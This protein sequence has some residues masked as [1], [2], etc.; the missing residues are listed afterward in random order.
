[1]V[2]SRQV[3]KPSLIHSSVQSLAPITRPNQEWAISWQILDPHR[4]RLPPPEAGL[5]VS[6]TL[7]DRN[8]MWGLVMT[9]DE[10]HVK[11]CSRRRTVTYR[12]ILGITINLKKQTY[13]FVKN[14]ALSQVKTSSSFLETTIS[15][16]CFAL[17]LLT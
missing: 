9:K 15:N 16:Y 11:W 8:T 13:T 4:D 7:W 6:N 1:M 2:S 3:A 5:P 12:T 17:Y 14:N 10:I